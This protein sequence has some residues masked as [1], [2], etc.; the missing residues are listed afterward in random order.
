[1][2][3]PRFSVFNTILLIAVAIMGTLLVVQNGGATMTPFRATNLVET[4]YTIEGT[5]APIKGTGGSRGPG[6][7]CQG[8]T[9]CVNYCG[10]NG[11]CT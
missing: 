7:S 6:S 2:N 8:S 1:M 11:K 9:Q 10:S 3:K 4:Q 5:V